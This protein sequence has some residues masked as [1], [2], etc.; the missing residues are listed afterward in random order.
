MRRE[1]CSVSG[2]QKGSNH[3]NSEV[4]FITSLVSDLML[5]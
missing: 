3:G 4:G 5:G 2:A 1:T